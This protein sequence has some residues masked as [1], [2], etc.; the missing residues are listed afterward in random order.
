MKICW[1]NT[2][3]FDEAEIVIVG[4]PDESKSHS[5]RKGTSEAPH[6]IR[7]ISSIRDTYKR[8]NNI[9]LG[10][11]FSGINK[12]VYD[13][14][15]I[16]RSEVTKVIDKIVS[17]SK[18]PLAIGGDHSIS[19]EIIKSVS[20]KHGQISLVYF[21]AHPDFIGSV[22]GYYGSVFH[23]VLPFID[24]KSSIQIGVR[25]P[26]QEEINNIKKYDLTVITPFDIAKNGI[27][28]VEETILNKI[29]T[30]VYV[31]FDMDAIDP[32]YA[33]GVSVPVPL[34]LRNTEAII[35]LKSL[36]KKVVGLD[37]MEVCPN[38]DIK[39]RTSHLASRMIAEAIS[40]F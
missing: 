1:A 40:S 12:K 34:G 26:E 33:P 22:Q 21:D 32:A 7:E 31:S 36:M 3:N 15:N 28:K 10:L 30:S 37:I 6:K 35:L 8:G 29:G 19:A 11:P 5:L 23:D 20:K 2:D 4:I 38:Y 18:I 14:G 39:D 9:S 17:K 16:E 27:T 24:I 13:Y 25:T